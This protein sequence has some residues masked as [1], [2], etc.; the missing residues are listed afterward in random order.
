MRKLNVK[1]ISV[2]FSVAKRTWIV[3]KSLIF[4]HVVWLFASSTVKTRGKALL[5]IPRN[6]FLFSPSTPPPPQHQPHRA[7]EQR[8]CGK[9]FIILA[10]IRRQL[11]PEFFF[12]PLLRSRGGLY[13]SALTACMKGFASPKYEVAKTW[14]AFK[15]SANGNYLH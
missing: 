15:K 14:Q 3:H 7:L 5:S 4:R 10:K 12:S 8:H 13:S 2:L 6:V 1:N 11:I 9:L